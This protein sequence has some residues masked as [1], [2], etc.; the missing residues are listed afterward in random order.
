MSKQLKHK[1]LFALGNWFLNRGVSLSQRACKPYMQS[2][3]YDKV[4]KLV[5]KDTASKYNYRIAGD[6]DLRNEDALKSEICD[7]FLTCFTQKSHDL[8]Y[9]KMQSEKWQTMIGI[10]PATKTPSGAFRDILITM[11][12]DILEAKQKGTLENTHIA[13]T[14]KYLFDRHIAHKYGHDRRGTKQAV[15][16]AVDAGL[17]H[18]GFTYT[19]DEGN[20]VTD[21]IDSKAEAFIDDTQRRMLLQKVYEII[22]DPKDRAT[23][24]IYHA[25]FDNGTT[26]EKEH[27]RKLRKY[28]ELG[29][30][31]PASIRQRMSRIPKKYLELKK[32]NP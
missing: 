2:I 16:N 12:R 23:L 21:V 7:L 24:E 15:R 18:K 25:C 29:L 9:P 8:H 10:K 4:Y 20:T 19:D 17:I 14:V 32:L 28:Q 3:D 6:L 22:T 31:T 30:C 11:Y 26:I 5:N 13:E 1:G 27:T